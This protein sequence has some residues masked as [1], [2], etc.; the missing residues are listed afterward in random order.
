MTTVRVKDGTPVEGVS[1]CRTCSWGVAR[2][3]YRTSDDEVFCR[4]I[5]PNKRVPFTV[6]E[7]SAYTNRNTPSLYSMEKIAWVL[8]TKSAGRSIGFVTGKR[9]RE[10]E[11][12]EAEIVPATAFDVKEE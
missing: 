1:L 12:E 8:L 2:R 7:C 11:G 4:F 6:R 10:L 9:F 5:Q 3:G